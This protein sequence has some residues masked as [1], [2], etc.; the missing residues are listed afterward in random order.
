MNRTIKEQVETVLKLFPEARNSNR[1]LTIE[2]WRYW[3][4]EKLHRDKED[5]RELWVNLEDVLNLP[6][7]ES[8]GRWRR[9]FQEEGK[10]LPTDYRV[11]V[12]RGQ[13]KKKS[14]KSMTKSMKCC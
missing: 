14:R 10:Y 3:F 7:Q 5:P 9:K 4:P 6:N 11:V 1:K 13:M 12:E 8:V 2:L